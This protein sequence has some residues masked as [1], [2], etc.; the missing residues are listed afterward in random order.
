MFGWIQFDWMKKALVTLEWWCSK[1]SLREKQSLDLGEC[2]RRW[3]MLCWTCVCVCDDCHDQE[4]A[5]KM[6][7]EVD[8]EN[9][10]NNGPNRK[11][12]ANSDRQW[13][14]VTASNQCNRTDGTSENWQIHFLC[15][16][17]IFT[18]TFLFVCVLECNRVPPSAYWLCLCWA[19][20]LAASPNT[21]FPLHI[22]IANSIW[23]LVF[24]YSFRLLPV[25][26]VPSAVCAHREHRSCR[27]CSCELSV[28]F[29]WWVM[30]R[31]QNTT[32]SS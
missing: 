25:Y 3:K 23:F 1:S 22:L 4:V 6:Q 5:L 32:E 2:G 16:S 15:N 28:Q 30:M 17:F 31:K 19:E 10:W 21:N 24:V 12:R 7:S 11:H 18:V 13:H 29:R 14:F 9:A 8:W 26:T 27:S 20:S